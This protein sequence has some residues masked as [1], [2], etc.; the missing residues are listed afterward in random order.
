M[1][2]VIVTGLT[3][4]VITVILC[5]ATITEPLRR[6]WGLRKLLAC[7][8]CTSVW[9]SLAVCHD[10]IMLSAACCAVANITVL[11]IHLSMTTYDYE[12]EE[13]DD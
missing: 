10:M 12:D 7:P 6:V 5:T 13:C 9:V 4:G 1:E 2:A 3:A 8:F 11:L